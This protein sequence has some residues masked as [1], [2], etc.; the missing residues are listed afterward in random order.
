[1]HSS[2]LIRLLSVPPRPKSFGCHRELQFLVDPHAV[3]SGAAVDGSDS[4]LKSPRL[5]SSH[6][7]DDRV[8][9]PCWQVFQCH[10]VAALRN[11]LPD[12]ATQLLVLD[13]RPFRDRA[14]NAANLRV[15]RQSHCGCHGRSSNGE[16]AVVRQLVLLRSHEI[17]LNALL[18][19]FAALQHLDCHRP[20]LADL[21]Q[22]IGRFGRLRLINVPL[23]EILD[24]LH[25]QLLAQC[26]RL[27]ILDHAHPF[28][29]TTL[30]DDQRIQQLLRGLGIDGA[31]RIVCQ[32]VC[33]QQPAVRCKPTQS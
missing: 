33:A 13:V 32:R 29:G 26:A 20:L 8:L 12:H 28:G 7:P 4:S 23:V 1:M 14:E 16:A 3:A 24:R 2:N 9:S 15:R 30:H 22:R 17:G 5:G 25:W 21:L 11:L 6:D 10:R 27:A 18:Q 31:H 19:P